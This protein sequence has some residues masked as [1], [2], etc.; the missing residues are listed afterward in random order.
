MSQNAVRPLLGPVVFLGP[1]GAGKGTQARELSRRLGIPHI[2]TGDMFRENVE[3]GTP[4]G[5][6]AKHIMEAG[7]LVNDDLVNEMVRSRIEREDC[8]GGFLLDGYPRTLNQAEALQE[9]LKK[10]GLR[11][12]VVINLN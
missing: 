3:K 12:P 4:L 6:A 5:R 10:I 8:Q 2:S 1:P 11:E 7:E 9:M